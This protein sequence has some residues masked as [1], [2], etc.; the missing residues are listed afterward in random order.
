MFSYTHPIIIS[1]DL[2]Y[3]SLLVELIKYFSV[4][5]HN[6]GIIR[7]IKMGEMEN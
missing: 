7:Y 4:S 2:D 5:L 3:R 6:A 1:R